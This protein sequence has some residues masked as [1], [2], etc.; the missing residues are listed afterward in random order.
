MSVA[1][2]EILRRGNLSG[3]VAADDAK[4]AGKGKVEDFKI[5]SRHIW[6]GSQQ[7]CYMLSMTSHY[8]VL[9]Q[10]LKIGGWPLNRLT[11]L[12]LKQAHI[13]EIQLL[14]PAIAEAMQNGGWLFLI[15][16]P[17]VPYAPA[18][19][20]FGIAIERIRVVQSTQEGELAWACEQV[21]GNSA[22]ACCLYWPVRDRL[23]NKVLKRLQLATAK[24]SQLNF[25]FRT[26]QA[27]SQS[28]PASLRLLIDLVDPS[29]LMNVKKRH[30]KIDII[31][32]PQ[33]W[34]G[35]SL[36]LD[37]ELLDLDRQTFHGHP[38]SDISQAVLEKNQREV[39]RESQ[40]R[41]QQPHGAKRCSG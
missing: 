19:I 1:L 22:V 12:L 33:G 41:K 6:Q 27:M 21:M 5:D 3:G 11:E 26:Q 16:P 32:Q 24:G 36:L 28:S 34:N 17:F 7:R 13:G 14:L 38:V 31:K 8:P 39:V 15:N 23:S 25:I 10:A 29:H 4:G 2:E 40:N 20:K 30:L 35:Q 18:W 37:L 9:D